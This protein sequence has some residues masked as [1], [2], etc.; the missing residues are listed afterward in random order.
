MDQGTGRNILKELK[1]TANEYN[2][3]VT[4]YYVRPPFSLPTHTRAAVTNPPSPTD[5]IYPRRSPLQPPRQAAPALRLASPH[6]NLLGHR[7]MLPRCGDEPPGFVRGAVLP[8]S[9]R[10]WLVA[11]DLA[12]AVLLVSAGRA[13]GKDSAGD[14]GREFQ[15]GG[16][17]GVGVCV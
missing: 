3:V 7:A 15:C 14:D 6:R 1:M 2:L 12:A 9:V 10:G 13:G 17:R 16:E 5:P 8:G 11:R 4:M